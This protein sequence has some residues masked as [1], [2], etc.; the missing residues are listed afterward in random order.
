MDAI[1]LSV[2]QLTEGN[3]LEI[4]VAGTAVL[5]AAIMNTIAK[6]LIAKFSGSPELRHTVVRAFGVIVIV[7]VISGAIAI[8]AL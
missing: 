6:G 1:T 3:E 4:Q 5:I 2:T 8:L 7:G